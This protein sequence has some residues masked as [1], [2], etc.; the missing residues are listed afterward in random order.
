MTENDFLPVIYEDRFFVLKLGKGPLKAGYLQLIPKRHVLSFAELGTEEMEDCLAIIKAIN[1]IYNDKFGF[2][3]L[4]WENGSAR[5]NAGGF[6]ANSIGHAHLHILPHKLSQ[7]AVAK[8]ASDRKLTPVNLAEGELQAGYKN[9]YYLLYTDPSGSAF[10]SRHKDPERQYLR[11]IIASELQIPRAWNW[12]EAD[13]PGN[14]METLRLL[15]EACAKI[16]GTAA[17]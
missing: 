11:K 13:F 15:G 14:S 6:F 9:S 10:I 16:S 4:T 3:P 8:V 17:R 1:T 2:I 5:Q 12:R 7:R